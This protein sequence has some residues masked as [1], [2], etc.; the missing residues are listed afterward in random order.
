MENDLHNFISTQLETAH[1][2]R[3]SVRPSGGSAAE[4][5][6]EQCGACLCERVC[7]ERETSTSELHAENRIKRAKKR[8]CKDKGLPATV[9]T[10]PFLL[11]LLSGPAEGDQ[12][13]PSAANSSRDGC[14]FGSGM[15]KWKWDGRETGPRLRVRRESHLSQVG[16]FQHLAHVASLHRKVDRTFIGVRSLRHATTPECRNEPLTECAELLFPLE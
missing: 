15:W 7:L 8:M 12:R 10:T 4:P 9:R 11:R 16:W 2:K 14:S 6:R 1:R 5:S 3:P 13:A